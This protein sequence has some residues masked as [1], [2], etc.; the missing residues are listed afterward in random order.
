MTLKIEHVSKSFDRASQKVINDLSLEI[1]QG[2]FTA[3]LGPSGCG[4]TT[5]LRIVAGLDR[6]NAGRVLMNDT[7]WLDTAKDFSMAPEKRNIGMVFQSYAVWP[8][9]T[10][11]DNVAFPLQIR[12]QSRTEIKTNVDEILQKVGLS[13]FETRKPH[14]LSGG[15]QQRVA[16]AR[17]L[18]QKPTLLLLDEPLSNLDASL[19]ADLRREI[20]RLQQEFKITAIIVTHDWVDASELSDDIIVINQGSIAQRGKASEIAKNPASDFVAKMLT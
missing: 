9:M 20:K 18:V 13:G 6:P 17:A 2:T 16:L 11:F 8:H 12:K 4:K 5:L 7:L 19:R 3:L 15:Q 1:N 10:V 14:A